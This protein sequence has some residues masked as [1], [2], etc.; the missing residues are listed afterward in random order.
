MSK[1]KYSWITEYLLIFIIVIFFFYLFSLGFN[2][3]V[4]Y[5][6]NQNLQYWEDSNQENQVN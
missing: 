1:N 5:E 2:E 6:N 3:L 4:D